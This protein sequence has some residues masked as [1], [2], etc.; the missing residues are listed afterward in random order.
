MGFCLQVLNV[1]KCP[2]HIY[3]LI[4]ERFTAAINNK[5]LYQLT[6]VFKYSTYS[7]LLDRNVSC[8]FNSVAEVT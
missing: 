5:Q 2:R 3:I 1:Q 7:L 4:H 6:S 8:P